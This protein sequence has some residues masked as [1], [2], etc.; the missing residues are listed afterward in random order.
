MGG[1][2]ALPTDYGRAGQLAAPVRKRRREPR[3]LSS[4][5]SPVAAA[6]GGSL[7]GVVELPTEEG[8]MTERERRSPSC[9]DK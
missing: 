6:A 1:G 4:P 2:R 5:Q 7:G 3:L 9:V 8:G